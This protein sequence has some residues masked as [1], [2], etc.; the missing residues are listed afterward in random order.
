MILN[1]KS[2]TFLWMQNSEFRMKKMEK[3][4]KKK[5]QN[6]FFLKKV[7]TE[8]STLLLCYDVKIMI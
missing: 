4:H 7:N 2:F 1:E 5:D 3:K 8:V 6:N